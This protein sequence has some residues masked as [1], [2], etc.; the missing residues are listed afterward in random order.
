MLSASGPLRRMASRRTRGAGRADAELSQSEGPCRVRTP[1][2]A[3]RLERPHQP[4]DLG[5]EAV[6]VASPA[7][8]G[9]ALLEGTS[10]SALFFHG[11]MVSIIILIP[12][13]AL[14]ISPC[15]RSTSEFRNSCSAWSSDVNPSSSPIELEVNLATDDLIRSASVSI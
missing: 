8:T 10:E 12:S 13:N 6:F 9:W 1:R 5:L 15:T 11:A 7:R 4:V 3:R 2:P 14:L